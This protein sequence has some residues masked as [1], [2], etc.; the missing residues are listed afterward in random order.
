MSSRRASIGGRPSVDRVADSWVRRGND[1]ARDDDRRKHEPSQDECR[2]D[3]GSKS[4]RSPVGD[5]QCGDSK[6]DLFTARLTLDVTPELRGRLKVIAFQRGVTVTALLRELLE[7]EFPADTSSV[8]PR[9]A[10]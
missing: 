7:R 6:I 1:E 5:S 2:A 3:A 8:C 10:R 4:D 9:A